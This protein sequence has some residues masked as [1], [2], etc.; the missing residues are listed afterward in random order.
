MHF[1]PYCVFKVSAAEDLGLEGK[2]ILKSIKLETE[3]PN[4]LRSLEV[5]QSFTDDFPVF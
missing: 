4:I 3:S 2:V 1:I 5:D